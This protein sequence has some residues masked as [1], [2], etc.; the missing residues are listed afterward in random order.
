MVKDTAYYDVLGIAPDADAASVKKAYYLKARKVHP[1]KNPGN[2]QAATDFQALGEAY[3]V[4]SDPQQRERYDKLGKEA[5]SADAMMDPA[6][7]FGMVFGSARFEEYVGEL[8]MASIATLS[9][10]QPISQ[11]ELHVKL[12]GVQEQRVA[13][14]VQLL[15][16]RLEPYVRGD[17][18]GWTKRQLDEAED[19]S[20]AAFGE[21]MLSTI[22]YIYQRQAA[23]EA[24]KD[25]RMLGLPF[26]H[27]WLRDKGHNFKTQF[28]AVAGAV[29]IMQ[30]QR[31]SQQLGQQQPQAV[32][33]F[34]Q[35]RMGQVMESL[36]KI[37]VVDIEATLKPVT[38]R[39][40]TEPG[41]KKDQLKLRAKAL[42]K[43]GSIFVAAKAKY[44]RTNS[45]PFME[46]P[47]GYNPTS[48]GS[49]PPQQ[50]GFSSAYAGA[51]GQQQA[52]GSHWPN[53]PS[54]Q[55]GPPPQ[56][57]YETRPGGYAQ[58]SYAQA[59]YSQQTSGQPGPAATGYRAGQGADQ[60]RQAQYAG[61]PPHG[62]AP[63][64]APSAPGPYADIGAMSIH[65][66]KQYLDSRGIPHAGL[67]EKADLIQAA[68]ASQ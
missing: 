23:K 50:G 68:R 26:A 40:L 44:Q 20:G 19:L 49:V 14:L 48:S 37:N 10:D 30:V 63:A 61:A 27:E 55:G 21:A 12:R 24:G 64:G 22:G 43:L 35:Q 13:K 53:S 2:P 17:K 46:A 51:A 31:Q 42:K 15:K 66:L 58:P 38:L 4:L 34:F 8:Q 59:G 39:V 16:D 29:D 18:A 9:Q 60:Q 62:H 41:V 11:Q 47:P 25:V 52:T 1:D 32:E 54:F 6:A 65:D 33:A 57:G 5:M 36:W 7:V 56:Q 45:M 67:Y 28:G 3:Q